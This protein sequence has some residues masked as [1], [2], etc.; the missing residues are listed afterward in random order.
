MKKLLLLSIVSL[1]NVAINA[2]TVC[3]PTAKTAPGKSYLLPDSATNIVH[4][5]AGRPYDETLYIKAFK[6]TSIVGITATTDSFTI[7]LENA[8]IG[9]PSYITISSV[10]AVRGPNSLHNYKHICIKGDSLA[11][12]RLLGVVPAGTPA[13]TTALSIPFSVK[14]KIFGFL[15]TSFSTTYDNYDFVVDGPG[16]AACGLGVNGIYKNISSITALPN[17]TTSMLNVNINSATAEPIIITVSNTMGQVV[18]V[19][20]TATVIGNN[21]FPINVAF[22]NSGIYTLNIQNAEGRVVKKF[23]KQ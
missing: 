3:V 1:C 18:L 14:A 10:P 11:C 22:L 21:N 17:P 19:K 12:V 23:S 7:N 9:L 2:Q 4:A 15:D 16:S 6:D 13:G 8:A 20:N 5:C